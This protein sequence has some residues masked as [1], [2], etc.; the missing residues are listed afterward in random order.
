MSRALL[1]VLII[2]CFLA[3]PA[4]AE[5]GTLGLEEFQAL[6]EQLSRKVPLFAQAWEKDGKAEFFGGTTRDYLYWVKRQFRD[7]RTRADVDRIKAALLAK[8]VIDVQEFII[9]DSD[10][11][12]VS[13]TV[14]RTLTAADYKVKKIDRISVERFATE[15]REAEDEKNQGHIPAEKIRLGKDGFIH[16]EGFEGG[17]A[18]IL[19]GPLSVHFTPDEIFARTHFAELGIN[20][21]VLLALRYLRLV[22]MDYYNT[23]GTGVPNQAALL[24]LIPE[25]TAQTLKAVFANAA[26]EGRLGPYLERERFETWINRAIQ[27]AFRSYTNP[28]AAKILFDHFGVNGLVLAYPGKIHSYND[29][30]FRRTPEPEKW[31]GNL[32]KYGIVNRDDFFQ[33]AE[34]FFTDGFFYHGAG[35]PENYRAILFQNILPST[36]GNAGKGAYGVPLTN[37]D[38]AIRWKS[39][40]E[41]NV[42]KIPIRSVARVVDVKS[43]G[44][45]KTVWKAFK[46]DHPLAT[47]DDFAEAFGIDIVRYAY[48]AGDAFV[49]KDSSVFG[50]GMPQGYKLKLMSTTELLRLAG[51]AQ[52]RE[53]VFDVL[54]TMALNKVSDREFTLMLHGLEPKL[55]RFINATA[56]LKEVADIAAEIAPWKSFRAGAGLRE[57]LNQRIWESI[58]ITPVSRERLYE[59]TRAI[60]AVGQP[61]PMWRD[62]VPHVREVIKGLNSPADLTGFVEAMKACPLAT[63]EASF[64][65]RMEK[66]LSKP[67]R[68][69]AMI[70]LPQVKAAIKRFAEVEEN[71]GPLFLS[72]ISQSQMMSA[73]EGE[74]LSRIGIYGHSIYA[75]GK[76]D[77]NHNGPGPGHTLMIHIDPTAKIVDI[78]NGPG[79]LAYRSFLES[80]EGSEIAGFLK[81]APMKLRLPHIHDEFAKAIGADIL[82]VPESPRY[83]IKNP[84]V[85][86][87]RAPGPRGPTSPGGGGG[88]NDCASLLARLAR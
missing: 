25:K 4:R 46:R 79:A 56:D 88:G 62:L 41:N 66:V 82:L 32:S 67:R 16:W 70:M 63:E 39:G 1:S 21:P 29:Y 35:K 8:T 28:T 59:V 77:R 50:P 78:S 17:I 10:V 13:D 53:Q 27:R 40:G 76:R 36:G 49:V 37:I 64:H 58:P 12:I 61:S 18:E 60:A 14:T 84:D 73:V 80:R 74:S 30:V 83:S 65:D 9:G 26:S 86:L 15:G 81:T 34:D 33:P 72:M 7:A 2:F 43:D 51:R 45:G 6:A 71:A 20:H 31:N 24:Q 47:I 44:L 19:N 5:S 75:S 42:V 11:D 22:A 38:F 3:A 85:I 23:H 57:A 69:L 54:R 55:L 48:D 87:R 68:A 52:T